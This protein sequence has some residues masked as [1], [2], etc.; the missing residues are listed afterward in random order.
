MNRL[1]L[2]TGMVIVIVLGSAHP[3]VG[4]QESSPSRVAT[5]GLPSP[6]TVLAAAAESLSVATPLAFDFR[7]EEKH[8]DRTTVFEGRGLTEPTAGDRRR[9]RLDGSRA[10]GESGRQASSRLV[11]ADDGSEVT[12]IDHGEQIE[13][14]SPLYRAGGILFQVWTGKFMNSLAAPDALPPLVGLGPTVLAR[15]QIQG[16][17]CDVLELPIPGGIVGTV[18]VGTEDGLPR[19]AV[20]VGDGL[21]SQTDLSNWRAVEGKVAAEAFE[22]EGVEGFTR[23]EFTLGGPPAGDRAPHF[24]LAGPDGSTLS[25]TDLEGRVVILDFW[26]T[27]C[28]PCRASMSDLQE[29]STEYADRP[30]EI[31]GVTY[32]ESGDPAALIEELGI[33]YPWYEGDSIAPAY[34][35][36]Q[37]GL[38]TMFLIGPDGRIRDFFYGYTGAESAAR[39]RQAVDAALADT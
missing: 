29:L 34:G 31:I 13:W 24:E 7:V 5:D 6:E 36:D 30:L 37:S 12:V 2:T 38:P 17:S 35:V 33:T 10:T 22:L 32:Q 4:R 28:I 23:R 26:A 19:R 8:G 25:L 1:L 14:G 18:Y 16:Q 27:W 9:I 3:S 39:L 20:L 11:V 15:E 21:R